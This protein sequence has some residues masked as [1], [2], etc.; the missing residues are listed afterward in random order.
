VPSPCLYRTPLA[1]CT[2]DPV[3][4]TTVFGEFQKFGRRVSLPSTLRA[5]LHV[6]DPRKYHAFRAL[7]GKGR[8]QHVVDHAE[9]CRSRADSQS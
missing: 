5:L 4:R 6:L 1:S 7:L 8:Q 2:D 9:D 3:K